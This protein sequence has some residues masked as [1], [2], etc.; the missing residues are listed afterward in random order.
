MELLDPRELNLESGKE[1]VMIARESIERKLWGRK[2]EL[3][4]KNPVL[5][6]RGMGFVTLETLYGDTTELRGC[7]G[8]LRPVAEI[9]KVI[10][11]AALG[12]AFSDPRFPPL[13]KSEL[14]SIVIEVTVLSP[15]SLLV[16]ENRW[17]I[18]GKV[19]IGIHG[20]VVEREPWYNG[21]L[22]PQVAPE[23]GWDSQTFLAEGCLKAGMSPDCWLDKRTKVSVFTAVIF[24]E[25]SPRGEVV[26][27]EPR[28]F[29][30]KVSN[31]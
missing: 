11:Q 5:Q 29:V 28:N 30:A 14:E 13:R 25:R 19:E 31:I 10:A 16:V 12:A 26:Q 20:I 3:E 27:V 8:Y 18:P 24:R 1:L 9:W 6:K 15:P 2:G 23:N 17:E 22:L 4:V 7:I 21:V